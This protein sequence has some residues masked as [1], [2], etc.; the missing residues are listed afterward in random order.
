MQ[1]CLRASRNKMASPGVEVVNAEL[2]VVRDVHVGSRSIR[3]E[4]RQNDEQ[5]F[6]KAERLTGSACV[7][8]ATDT[9]FR[10]GKRGWRAGRSRGQ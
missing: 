3:Q 4:V 5:N 2:R 9:D 7:L 10:L 1:T 8:V 6:G